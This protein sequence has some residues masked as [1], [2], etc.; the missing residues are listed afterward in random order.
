MLLGPLLLF[1]LA[2]FAV[3][4]CSSECAN[5]EHQINAWC[6]E[7]GW[8]GQCCEFPLHVADQ[9]AASAALG[10]RSVLTI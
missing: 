10:R 3:P 6:C 7:T 5:C 2:A 1:L 4:G 8:R 9:L